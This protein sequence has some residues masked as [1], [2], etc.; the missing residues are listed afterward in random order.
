M[1]I[2]I[3]DGYQLQ[4]VMKKCGRDQFSVDALEA[5]IEFYDE[6]DEGIECDPIAICC[7]W[8]EYY[9]EDGCLYQDYGYVAK[10]KYPCL[11]ED[12]EHNKFL[13]TARAIEED[14]TVIYLST[15]SVL[16]QMF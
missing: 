8:T 7:E 9:P 10:R 16:V 15:G 12:T 4:Q 11:D 1:K 13:L 3:T 14:T 2:S 6:F 5:L